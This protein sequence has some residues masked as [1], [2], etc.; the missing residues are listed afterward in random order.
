MP[1]RVAGRGGSGGFVVLLR[2]RKEKHAQLVA[3]RDTVATFED[4]E[5]RE[6][7]GLEVEALLAKSDRFIRK[8]ERV[9]VRR[10]A[11]LLT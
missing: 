3:M 4:D 5:K 1:R 9:I 7:L 11:P 6:A 10:E 2:E 8:L